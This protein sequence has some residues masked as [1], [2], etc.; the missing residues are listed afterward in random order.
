MAILE[1]FDHCCLLQACCCDTSHTCD[2][3]AALQVQHAACLIN[4]DVTDD[5]VNSWLSSHRLVTRLQVTGLIIS[6]V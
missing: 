6:G 4:D 5:G 3:L 1:L 2:Q